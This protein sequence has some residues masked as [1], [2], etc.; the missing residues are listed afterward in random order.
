[1]FIRSVTIENFMPYRGSFTRTFAKGQIIS[2]MAQYDGDLSRSNRAGKTS[3]LDAILFCLYGKSRSKRMVQLVHSGT[4]GAVVKVELEEEGEHFEIVRSVAADGKGKLELKGWEGAKKKASQEII[5]QLIGMDYTEFMATAFFAQNDI[6]QFMQADPQAKKQ[7]LMR[8]LQQTNWPQYESAAGSYKAKLEERRIKLKASLDALGGAIDLDAL[9]QEAVE[10]TKAQKKIETKRDK[11]QQQMALI[12]VEISKLDQVTGFEEE[13]T[14]LRAEIDKLRRNRPDGEA[15]RAALDKVEAGLKKYPTISKLKFERAEQLNKEGLG[16]LGEI[17]A[18]IKQVKERLASIKSSMTGFCPVLSAPCDRIEPDEKMIRA[19]EKRLEKLEAEQEERSQLT[20]KAAKVI[21]VFE[22]Q[23]DLTAKK[24][25]LTHKL[26]HADGLEKQIASLEKKRRSL[27][28][29]IPEDIDDQ[30]Q[31]LIDKLESLSR[32]NGDFKVEI[33]RLASRI[34]EAAATLKTARQAADRRQA[35][36]VDLRQIEQELGDCLFV[37]YMFGKNGIP[38]V[39]IENSFEQ[40]EEDANL[41]LERLN[42]SFHL[43]F[44]STRELKDWEP[45]CLMCGTLFERGER[46]HICQ[47]CGTAREKKRRDE[48][49]LK[50]FEG[51]D[52]R[53]FYMDSGGGKILLSVAIR[54]ALIRLARLRKGSSWGVLFLDEVFGQLDQANRTAMIE[55]ITKTIVRDLGFEQV[56]VISHDNDIQNAMPNRL[57]VNRVNNEYSEIVT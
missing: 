11:I 14:K 22:Y 23:R 18:E 7:I 19:E 12:Q 47:E 3:F 21:Q 15:F 38:S 39:E 36:E 50:I 34:G 40:I 9:R 33:S 30:R 20:T 37:S 10:L 53:Y 5:D 49:Q 17:G 55:L 42:T 46:T 57:I 48:L 52:E 8:W 6:D 26:A 28:K 31:E 16:R 35:A 4:D 24:D 43:E 2:I 51:D 25:T 54:L 13:A 44:E 27:L 56:F 41:I 1:M 29:K 45:A 32:T